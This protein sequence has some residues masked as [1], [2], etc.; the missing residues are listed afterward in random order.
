VA[1]VTWLQPDD[2]A[3]SESLEAIERIW[4]PPGGEAKPL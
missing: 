4:E 2:P 3:A 1:W